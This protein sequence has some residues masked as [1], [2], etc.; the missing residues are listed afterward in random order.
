MAKFVKSI[1]V[2]KGLVQSATAEKVDITADTTGFPNDTS[3]FLRGDGTFATPPSSGSGITDGDKGDITISNSGETFTIDNDSVTFAKMQELNAN[4]IIGAVSA[5]NPGEITCTS[6]GR[7]LLDDSSSS[8]Q[9]NTLGL[10]TIATQNSSNVSITGGTA[11]FDNTGLSVKDT[12][13]SHSL[14]L[15]PGSDLTANHTLTLATG[16]AD[17]IL[18]L[19]G[20]ATLSG[21]NTGD[22]TI[23][24]TGDVTG[25]GTGSFATTIGND[26]VTYAKMQNVSA[27]SKLLGRGDSGSGDP[28][29]ITLGTGLSISGTTLNATASGSGDVSGPGSSTDNGLV[30]FDG[31]TGKIIQD[32]SGI[33][34]SDSGLIDGA[35]FGN[36]GL[37][38]QDTD[39]SHTLTVSPG[40]NLSANRTLTIT[41]GDANRGFT[42]SGDATLSGTNTGDQTI[43]LT[44]DVTGSGTGSFSATI[45][46][47]KVTF[48]KMQNISSGVVV[49]RSTASSGDPEEITVGTGLSISGGSLSSTITQYT[50]EAAQDA[51][52]GIC[53]DTSTIDFVYDDAGNTLSA[54][55]LTTMSVTTAAGGVCLSG[56]SAS[57][58]S[59]R[60]YGT[61][62]G[63]TKGYYTFSYPTTLSV[64]TTGGNIAL[65][66]DSSPSDNRYY[67]TNS[68]GTK[69]YYTFSY[70]TTMS[71][72][73]TG[74]NLALVN[75]SASPGNYKLYGTDSGGTKGW[76]APSVILNGGRLSLVYGDPCPSSDTGSQ[77][78]APSATN[79]ST[80]TLTFS[81][82]HGWSTGQAVTIQASEGGLTGGTVYYIRAA[83]TTTLTFH[84]TFADAQANTN[85]VNLTAS[86]TGS[87]YPLLY[88]QTFESD[89]LTVWDGT[90]LITLSIPSGLFANPWGNTIS[91]SAADVFAYSNSGTLALE[92]L[93]WSS[94]TARATAITYQNGFLAKSGDATRRFIG[95]VFP[96]GFANAIY[97]TETKRFVWNMYNR[98]RRPIKKIETTSSWTYGTQTWR[99]MNNSTSNRVE[100][101]SG[102]DQSTIDLM[103]FAG[104]IGSVS[105]SYGAIGIAMDATNTNNC[106]LVAFG[107]S[108]GSGLWNHA[109]SKLSSVCPIG[110][111]YYQATEWSQPNGGTL[112]FYSYDN[113]GGSEPIRQGGISG[114]WEC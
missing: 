88:Y 75:D 20:D 50:D 16:D 42:L 22:Q 44:G 99:S 64:T 17:M 49:G 41:T 55:V 40:S 66:N 84:T 112:T 10:G 29:E 94:A 45:G 89:K 103:A 46:N 76:Y 24:L 60:Y 15:V 105:G 91:G 106:D 93:Q 5:G 37:K 4:T 30:R 98:V 47:D 32:G 58:G 82:A 77:P 85:K 92:L 12:D 86:I 97:D 73:T 72:T 102:L 51:V 107:Y 38:V 31:A 39:S 25:S 48:A 28:E 63:G 104:T 69:G 21:K 36:T 56:D 2:S 11:V 59:T 13:A 90:N 62:S 71:I 114:T 18:T 1:T 79:T 53:I 111:H 78:L 3:K 96:P 74:G 110:Y 101:V 35:S 100:V 34:V 52:G 81:V 9:R 6:A 83:S 67:G 109:W 23:T 7:A 43:T 19:T 108:G 65:V 95:T 57:P 33:T 80:E 113:G 61:N 54:N 68:G 70:P 27:A 8:E 87:I 26:K 14:S